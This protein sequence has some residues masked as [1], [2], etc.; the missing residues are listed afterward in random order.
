MSNYSKSCP[1]EFVSD[2]LSPIMS[3]IQYILCACNFLHYVQVNRHD[4]VIIFKMTI[5][6][7][8]YYCN[9]KPDN[10]ILSVFGDWADGDEEEA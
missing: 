9:V 4:T 10:V 1:A 6:K 3:P 2:S 7:S 5:Y 8:L